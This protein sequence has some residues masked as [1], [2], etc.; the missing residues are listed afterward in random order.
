VV[1]GCIT[2]TI[3]EQTKTITRISTDK[4][5]K[6]WPDE[7][8][9]DVLFVPSNATTACAS[10]SPTSKLK[11]DTPPTHDANTPLNDP[12]ILTADRPRCISMVDAMLRARAVLPHDAKH[13]AP[14][15]H[16]SQTPTQGRCTR[17][18]LP[19]QTLHKKK[20]CSD[21]FVSKRDP[22][23]AVRFCQEEFHI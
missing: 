9:E 18:G 7:E 15:V 14:W 2:E 10:T 8:D 12:I 5:L 20:F 17:A 21:F 6:P 1:V 4:L 13:P 16:L 11:T 19:T 3:A 22:H 23:S